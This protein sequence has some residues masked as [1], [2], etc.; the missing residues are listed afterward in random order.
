VRRYGFH[1][2][3]HH[4]AAA[5]A[6]AL[7]G[8]PIEELATVTCHLGSGASLAAVD[9]GRSVDTTMGFTP[10]DG[11]VM[12]SRPGALDPG[13]VPWIASAHG[14]AMADVER[15]LYSESGLV[16]LAGT[17]EMAAVLE[18]TD[19]DARLAVDVYVHRLRGAIAA[20]AAALGRLDVLVFTGGVGEHAPAIR[21]RAADGLG[22]LGVALD[23]D[24][25]AATTADGD[26]T[27]TGAAVRTL[28][29]TA[30]EDLE[31]ARLAQDVLT[32]F[33][34][35]GDTYRA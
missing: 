11:V 22:F 19:A 13:I 6:A 27:A 35:R 29:V 14:V 8:R 1:G 20:M 24:A 26:I 31:I 9:G 3:S 16:G 21:R 23:P 10:L 12:G 28:V 7:V 18:R 25:N 34:N 5:Q 30:R 15:A 33:I 32:R 4:W 2:L 17:G